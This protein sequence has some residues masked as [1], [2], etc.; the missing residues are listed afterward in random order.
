VTSSRSVALA[1]LVL[2]GALVPDPDL[3]AHRAGLWS[4]Q[5]AADADRWVEVHNLDEAKMSGIFHIEVLSRRRGAP[6]WQITHLA[7]HMAITRAALERSVV[8]PLKTG[9]VYPESFD[10]AFQVWLADERAGKHPSVCE[11]SVDRCLKR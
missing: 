10:S 6:A 9:A 7:P 1:A 11:S 2:A 8:K 4:L 3:F 5:P